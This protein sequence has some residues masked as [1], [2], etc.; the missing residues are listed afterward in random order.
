MI[1]VQIMRKSYGFEVWIAPT[2]E[3]V[4]CRPTDSL[5][6]LKMVSNYNLS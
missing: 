6:M 1:D 4:Y 2:A 3:Y 5:Y